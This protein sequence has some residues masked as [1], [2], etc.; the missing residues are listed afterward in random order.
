MYTTSEAGAFV[1]WLFRLAAG[2]LITDSPGQWIPSPLIV[3]FRLEPRGPLHG[4]PLGAESLV[5]A[6]LEWA[7]IAVR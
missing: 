5:F 4:G 7:I 2:V 3:S 6:W 1:Q